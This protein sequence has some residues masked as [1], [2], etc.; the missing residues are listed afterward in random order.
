REKFAAA[1]RY[2]GGFF[3]RE[4]RPST[5]EILVM[6]I[7]DRV[8]R[9][10]FPK[11]YHAETQVMIQLMS[12]DKD[13]MPDALAALAA[14]AAI[15]VSDIPFGGP[16]SEVRVVKV[17]GE[18]KINP[19]PEEIERSTLGLI[20]AGT[21]DNIMMVEGECKEVD[22]SEM[23]D[24]IKAAH[25][26][27]KIQC[28]AQ[29]ELAKEVGS[30]EKREFDHEPK[31]EELK[32][33]M[34][35]Q[36]YDKLYAVAA[37][38]NPVKAERKEAF[39]AV[40]EEY[41]EQFSEEQLEEMND[42]LL[43]KYFHDIEKEAIRN[44]VLDSQERIDGR[45]PDEIRPIWSEVDYL[46][47]AHGSAV[48]TRGETQSLTSVT[49]GTKLDEQMIDGAMI[50]G[51][52]KFILHYNFPGFS[53]G[54][55][56]PNRGPG[57]REVGHGNLAMRALKPM[58]PTEDE[59][60][61]YT[62]RVVSD[63][64]ESNGSSSMATVCAGTMALMDAGIKL[65]RPVSGIAMG[66]ISDSESGKYAILSD[67]LGDED[68]LGD[69]DFKVT[70]TTEGITACQMDIKVDG[71]S[72]D[73]LA[74]ALN[75]AKEGRLHILGE[76]A[77]SITEPRTE[78]KPHAPRM[79]QLRIDRELIGAVIGPGGKI[80]QE[81]QKE[82]GATVNIEEDEQGGKV[83]IFAADGEA[84]ENAMARIKAI[85]QQPEVGE[86]YDG[87]VKSIMPFGAFVEFL[88]GKDGLLHISEIKW[89]RVEN[90]SDVMEEG[91]E[92]KVKLIDID[93]KTGKFKLSR[94]V[95]LP[96]PPRPEKKDE[97]AEG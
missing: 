51:F 42:F 75:Q 46:P 85:V 76:M 49:L 20:V 57:R 90:V 32:A 17:D 35:K 6:R 62:V 14:S 72:Y 8:L 23:L 89:E 82:S 37:K 33:S 78:L 48:F 58:I 94:K 41:I 18:Y 93:K 11:D 5:E 81:I 10:L 65:K 1:G 91:E 9:P 43:G 25:E 54:E 97:Q 38:K 59:G 66:M 15:S 31:D 52:N 61:P 63:I 87:K 24:A 44:F 3:K 73:V 74:K 67:I 34:H 2:P 96:R 40:Y 16:I 13:V 77:K 19:T 88:P 80:I 28:K 50:S 47:S 21:S 95:L 60:N 69:M 83:S 55:V 92:I 4:A 71:L 84:L 36:V 27:I 7:V 79:E 39:K 64:L 68:H 22:E 30:T 12:L 26:E 70:G 45:Q 86:V 53:T 56:R 29:E